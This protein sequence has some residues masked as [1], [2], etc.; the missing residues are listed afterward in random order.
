MAEGLNGKTLILFATNERKVQEVLTNPF[1]KH[2][3]PVE[4]RH[5]YAVGNDTFRLD[6]YS[7]TNMLNQI[8]RLFK[9]PEPRRRQA[10]LLPTLSAS[11]AILHIQSIEISIVI[12]IMNAKY[13]RTGGCIQTQT[14]AILAP[15][16]NANNNE[17]KIIKELP[18]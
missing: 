12:N 11:V 8:E 13:R 6:Y 17:N 1:L 5:V 3:E 18:V 7:A 14:R 4:Q 15:L 16:V 9:S 10:S 2:L